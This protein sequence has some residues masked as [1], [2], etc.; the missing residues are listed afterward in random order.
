ML[1]KVSKAD[2]AL[3]D[4]VFSLENILRNVKT[5]IAKNVSR[6]IR[7]PRLIKRLRLEQVSK[8]YIDHT[9]LVTIVLKVPE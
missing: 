7:L 5:E 4:R 3:S 6:S 1:T 9:F 8:F 2:K